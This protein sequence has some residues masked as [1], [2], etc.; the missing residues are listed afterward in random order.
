VNIILKDTAVAMLLGISGGAFAQEPS[1]VLKQFDKEGDGAISVAEA[2]VA[3]RA[4]F[5]KLD[6]NHDGLVTEQEFVAARL[7]L[8]HG[9]DTDNDGR[10]TRSE[11]RSR[12][13]TSLRQ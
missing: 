12:F 9:L 13:L 10:V 3:S 11:L 6:S 1:S 7:A 8:L 5:E 4:Q 2:D